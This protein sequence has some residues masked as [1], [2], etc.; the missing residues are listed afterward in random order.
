ML[1]AMQLRECFSK[2]AHIYSIT[3][4]GGQREKEEPSQGLCQGDGINLAGWVGVSSMILQHQKAQGHGAKVTNDVSLSLLLLVD[5]LY[6]DD[7]EILKAAQSGKECL[8]RV[9]KRFQA[10]VNS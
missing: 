1:I 2:T 10:L 5:L 4:Y 3:I 7:T 8:K 9:T 6:V